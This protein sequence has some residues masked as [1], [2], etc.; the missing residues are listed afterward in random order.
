ML[1]DRLQESL[2][3]GGCAVVIRNTVGLAQ[4]TYLALRDT[5]KTDGIEVELFH[6][7]FPFGRRS[8][9]ENA[10][11]RRFGKEGG[12]AERDKR[13][14]VATQVVEQSLDLDFDVMVS[15]VAPVDL[16]LQR[17]GRLH[18]HDRGSR[19]AGVAEP[20]LWLIKPPLREDGLPDF[21][22]YDKVYARLILF[23]SYLA[24]SLVGQKVG[25]VRL[26]DDLESLV[27]QVYGDEL[28]AIPDGWKAALAESHRELVEKQ[29]RQALDAADVAISP[30]DESPLAQQSHQLEEDD[31]EA[32]RRIQAHTRDSE[33]TVQLIVVYRI[34]D[35]DYLDP[36]GREPFDETDKP[37]LKRTRRLLDN[38]LTI[39]HRGCVHFHIKHRTTPAGWRE[40]GLLRH[41]RLLRVD[42][43]GYSLP[44]DFFLKIDPEVGIRFTD[45]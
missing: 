4:E 6:A 14:L 27:E 23:R 40:C 42:E 38:E 25:F 17:A 36:L 10:V 34:G 33:P 15:D 26:P 2:A 32:A 1:A 11:L 28:P 22:R 21:R 41:H 12:A 5:L 30:P 24:L 37:G 44:G 9:I 45:D 18:R 3:G 19:V 20:R 13:V 8:E 7:R 16:V 31:P 35:G 39:S 43:H 29:E